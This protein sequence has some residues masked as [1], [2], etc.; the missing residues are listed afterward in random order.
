[1]AKNCA[2][3]GDGPD[4]FGSHGIC[5]AHKKAVLLQYAVRRAARAAEEATS[6]DRTHLVNTHRHQSTVSTGTL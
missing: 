2:W 6:N 1:M 4:E 3:C 5:E